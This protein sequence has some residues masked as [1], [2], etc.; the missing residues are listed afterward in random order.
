MLQ[1]LQARPYKRRTLKGVAADSGSDTGKARELL[2]GLGLKG[3]ARDIPSKKT[4]N[5]VYEMT[6]VGAFALDSKRH[7]R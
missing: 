4:G 3:L 5:L 1:A 7:T 6:S 2:G